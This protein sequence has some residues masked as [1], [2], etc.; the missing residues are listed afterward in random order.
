[1][2]QYL[3]SKFRK[4]YACLTPSSAEQLRADNALKNRISASS[5]AVLQPLLDELRA[6][7]E[8]LDC[9]EFSS[10]CLRL[11]YA[12][13]VHERRTLLDFEHV[14]PAPRKEVF[15]HT[16]SL[17]KRSLQIVS[18]IRRRSRSSTQVEDRLIEGKK[19]SENRLKRKQKRLNNAQQETFSTRQGG[20][21]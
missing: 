4:L 6:M 19:L 8:V 1:M 10:S 18:S 12:L 7:N 3:E 14:K 21:C 9:Q 17:C 15:Q 20:K 16:P 5:L 13:P 2:A 11:Y